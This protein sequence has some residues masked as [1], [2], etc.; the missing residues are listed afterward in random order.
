[1][2]KVWARKKIS[3]VL[4]FLLCVILVSVAGKTEAHAAAK[5]RKISGITYQV[6]DSKKKTATVRKASGSIRSADIAAKV[7]IKGK[8]YKVTSIS[9][10]AFQNCKKLR[11]VT[12]GKNIRTI[13]SRAFYGA[14]N[15]RSITVKSRQITKIGSSAFQGIHKKAKFSVPKAAYN[16]Y[17]KSF[18]KKSTGFKKTMQL[19]VSGENTNGD[20]GDG[21][22]GDT[23]TDPDEEPDSMEEDPDAFD[24]TKYTYS[25]TP[26][27]SD[28]CYYYYVKT[29]NP[30][31]KSFVFVDENNSYDIGMSSTLAY[32]DEPFADVN[33]TGTDPLRVKDGYIFYCGYSIDGGELT[34]KDRSGWKEESTG[35]TV[36][37]P[38]QL[39]EEQYLIN[40]FTDASMS[41]FEKMDAVQSGLSG[42][43]LYSGASV[44]GERK[45]QD[46]VYYGLSTSPHVDQNFYIQDPYYREGTKKLLV[47]SL[48]PF[49]YDSIGFPGLMGEVA[50]TIDPAVSVAWN[51]DYHWLIDVSYNGETR[52]YGG[53]GE[54]GGQGLRDGMVKYFY[55]F[56]GSA[57]DMCTK[58]TFE[59][60]RSIL[61]E[62]GSMDVP[63]DPKDPDELTWESVCR[64]VGAAGSY[65][66]VMLVNSIFGGGG[67]GFSFL[68]ADDGTTYPRYM[69]DVWYDGRYFNRHEYFEKGAKFSDAPNA[70]IVVKDAQI[71]FP[72]A[73]EGKTYLYNYSDIG[74]C[75]A[76]NAVTG[77]WKGFTR[78]DYDASK[79]VWVASIYGR[80]QC[81][82]GN[83]YRY[84][85]IEDEDFKDA[86][87]L[88]RAEVLAMGI[89]RNADTDPAGYYI[90]DMG[91]T[92][93][94]W[95]S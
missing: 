7:K 90:Y 8:T 9:E 93:G 71:R 26:L 6:S 88:T 83:S 30:D 23:E 34:L 44:L 69:S 48:Y 63:E 72:E 92:P 22:F 36:T 20:S 2:V 4:F 11:N 78:F 24:I 60:L 77:I 5:T 94:T 38:Q 18:T 32:E 86:C 74:R 41:F 85:P 25:V 81:R 45:K 31:P 14:K 51:A 68:Y 79:G 58:S 10:K 28:I 54:G 80:S 52:S 27:V 13:S 62:Y 43:C 47:S 29:D 91:T 1:M 61:D 17:K 89:D 37:I 53:Q 82:E 49:R 35:I 12:I 46:G 33:Y 21:L 76:Y 75:A 56:D 65:V 3:S 50:R 40:R 42:I 67:T 59:N 16:R 55:S 39:T 66:R 15:L 87:T 73:P 57:N 19:V 84:V 95:A 64:T 70:A